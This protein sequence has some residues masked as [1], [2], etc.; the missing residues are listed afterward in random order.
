[1]GF[2]GFFR[3]LSWVSR[4]VML[5]TM[6]CGSTDLKAPG[7]WFGTSGEFLP[8]S[9][10][11]LCVNC[12]CVCVSKSV[13]KTHDQQIM[14]IVFWVELGQSKLLFFILWY[15]N[16]EPWTTIR[17]DVMVVEESHI[18]MDVGGGR[19]DN[20]WRTINHKHQTP[21]KEQFAVGSFCMKQQGAEAPMSTPLLTKPVDMWW[22]YVD[23]S[24][25]RTCTWKRLVVICWE[26]IG[27]PF[28][29]NHHFVACNL[30]AHSDTS[31]RDVKWHRS[32]S[33]VNQCVV[34]SPLNTYQKIP[35]GTN[36][37]RTW[38]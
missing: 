6:W 36:P 14:L 9:S 37:D 3:R 28:H 27:S 2:P 22:G 29:F 33:Y 21:S 5:P 13:S 32:L 25:T 1:M 17:K 26:T 31:P 7:W 8:G 35:K 23:W 19:T 24:S 15:W 30:I 18:Q 10:L 20:Q 11:F 4:A 16:S 34:V 12:V 38:I